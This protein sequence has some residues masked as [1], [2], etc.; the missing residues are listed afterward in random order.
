MDSAII[1]TLITDRTQA[2]VDRVLRLN[3][4]SWIDLTPGERLDYLAGLKGAYKHTDLNRVESVARLL[5]DLLCLYGY[6]AE[7]VSK[8][9]WSASDLQRKADLRRY[10]A[11]IRTLRDAYFTLS[12][13][14]EPPDDIFHI[15]WREANAIEEILRDISQVLDYM[16]ESFHYVGQFHT[17][18]AIE[19]AGFRYALRQTVGELESYTIAQLEHFTIG[20]IEFGTL[21]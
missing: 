5:A 9:D 19:L 11:N 20:Q 4:V 13:T 15:T 12:A 7:L 14:P 17:G 8:C 16:L 3:R 1:A 10:L 2:D 21:T 18:E 6:T